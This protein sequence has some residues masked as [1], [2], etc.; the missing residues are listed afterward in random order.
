MSVHEAAEN[1]LAATPA[2]REPGTAIA[3]DGARVSKPMVV[4]LGEALIRLTAE[5]RVPLERATRLSVDVGGTE[6]NVLIALTQLGCRSRWVSRL[7]DNPL[8]RHIAGHARRHGVDL[9]ISWDS[10]G[11][12]GLYF[13]EQGSAPRPTQ[14]LYDRA[15]S[16]VS[17]LQPGMF[18]WPDILESAAVLHCT[19]ITCGLGADAEKTVLEAF[20][21]AT[22]AGA[23]ISFDLNYRR[24]LWPPDAA[25]ASALRVLPLVDVLFASPFDLSLLAGGS[26]EAGLAEKIRREHGLTY[27]VVRTQEE[28]SPGTLS[29]TVDVTGE[30]A[31]ASGSARATVLDAFGAGDAAAAAF[32]A[33]WLA[34]APIAR[35]ATETAK[36]S[37]YM[38]TIPG[39]T[40]MHPPADW[41]PDVSH[42]G[43]IM[44]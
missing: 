31:H 27:V 37:A 36:A 5:H 30:G 35:L 29:I 22:S 14:V 17:H 4:G 9:E 1:P 25:L 21:V 41:D 8:G 3:A 23:R 44:R 28:V 40:W 19:G 24:Q 11:R 26:T 7:P 33:H 16:S 15:G 6:L 13:V 38:Y 18:R 20:D 43:R 12:A 42:P 34:D 32:L 10:G 2:I 39:D